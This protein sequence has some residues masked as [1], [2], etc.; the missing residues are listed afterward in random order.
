MI[1]LVMIKHLQSPIFSSIKGHIRDT[2]L[3]LN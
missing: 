3:Q 2:Y 1:R